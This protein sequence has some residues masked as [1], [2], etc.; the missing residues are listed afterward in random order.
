[1]KFSQFIQQFSSVGW[2]DFEMAKKIGFDN[3]K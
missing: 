1:M 2:T 3:L